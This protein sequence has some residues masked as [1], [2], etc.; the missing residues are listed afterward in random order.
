MP[1]E[2]RRHQLY[3]EAKQVLSVESADELMS[4]LPPV[5][6]ADV[7]TKTDL[8]MIR[9]EMDALRSEMRG[10]MA[11]IEGKIDRVEDRLAGVEDRLAGVEGRISGVEGKF[12][13]LEG[14]IEG[15][16]GKIEGLEGKIEG[17]A[18]VIGADIARATDKMR[19]WT[20]SVLLSVAVIVSGVVFGVAQ[21]KR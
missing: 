5:G 10:D 20:V 21:L 15:L 19:V 4:Y 8:G 11:R 1:S 7:A 14:K 3:E 17:L 18:G 12:E 2:R 9:Y 16:E 6:W 13:G